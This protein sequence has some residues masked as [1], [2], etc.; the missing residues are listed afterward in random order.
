MLR[1][2]S[3]RLALCPSEAGG[4]AQGMTVNET[5]QFPGV[6]RMPPHCDACWEVHEEL[7]KPRR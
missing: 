2:W 1:M 3:K 5:H 4:R 7:F 6:R